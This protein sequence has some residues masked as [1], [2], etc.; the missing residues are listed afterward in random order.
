MTDAAEPVLYPPDRVP[1]RTLDLTL[2]R[3]PHILTIAPDTFA[4]P[5]ILSSIKMRRI[6]A[7][8]GD[9]GGLDQL[10]A[11]V[12]D[13]RTIE[14]SLNGLEQIILALMPG[15]AGEKFVAR[16]NSQEREAEGDRPAD[17]E[18]IDLLRQAIPALMFLLECYGLR[19]TRPSSTFAGT[20]NDGSTLN[21]GTSSTAGV[22]PAESE[23]TTSELPNT[24]T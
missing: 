18:P 12:A 1:G 11:G 22:S 10:A 9:L 7:T 23:S 19:P 4:V 17:P 2:K 13:P 20:S 5:Q 6:A 8:I 15:A 16:M 3:E 24:S 14:R 21:D